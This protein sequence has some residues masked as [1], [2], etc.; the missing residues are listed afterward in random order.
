MTSSEKLERRY[1]TW[2]MGKVSIGDEYSELCNTMLHTDYIFLVGND[3][4]RATDGLSLRYEFENKYGFV[5]SIADECSILEMFVKLAMRCDA[6][7]MYD[8]EYGN[9]ADLWFWE[10]LCNLGLDQFT[11]NYWNPLEINYILED[12]NYRNYGRNGG[13]GCAFPVKN[14]LHDLRT[15]EIWYQMMWW[16]GENYPEC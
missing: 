13:H 1:L 11:N 6:D 15:T 5:D 10:M 4:N 8:A 7:V 9:R 3:D 12:F 14:P 2:L 16:L